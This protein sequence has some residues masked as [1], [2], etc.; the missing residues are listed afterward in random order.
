MT[1]V[2]IST[3][4]LLLAVA[5]IA[6]I[7]PFDQRHIDD[8]FGSLLDTGEEQLLS[9]AFDKGKNQSDFDDFL[10]TWDAGKASL[11]TVL[12]VCQVLGK[13]TDISAPDSL[14]PRLK[15][16]EAVAEMHN[17]L[18]QE[19]FGRI[20][21][22]LN[23]EGIEFILI[24]GAAM[25]LLR[26]DSSRWMTDIDVMV[27]PVNY[28]AAIKV[29]SGLGYGDPMPCGYSTDLHIPGSNIAVAD[30][31]QELDLGTGMEER[32]SKLL[33]DRAEEIPAFS[34]KGMIPCREDMVFILLV[35]T[36][37]N[38]R[39]KQSGQSILNTFF[40]LDFLISGAAS[41]DWERVRADA[42]ETG[43][44]CQVYLVS[45]FIERYIA[46]LFPKGWNDSLGTNRKDL[47]KLYVDFRFGRSVLSEG[48]D[49]MAET[50]I[51][52]KLRTEQSLSVSVWLELVKAAKLLAGNRL[53]KR[54]ILRFNS[55]IHTINN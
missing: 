55:L 2:I 39:K 10:K 33:F 18:I 51:G 28:E 42:I 26:P 6:G 13:R 15:G 4:L 17:A 48:R 34:A 20:A 44:N 19:H 31:H 5:L 53:I 3:T 27:E 35:N 45:C 14:L 50:K 7:V 37:K 22:A 47:E 52:K 9:L 46:D 12:L 25:K 30:I 43:T 40:D 1:L 16:G 11:K 21:R 29:A 38:L 36:Y 49:K 8:V 23:Q 24:K 54:I 32:L 41:L